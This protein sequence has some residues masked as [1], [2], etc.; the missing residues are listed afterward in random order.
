MQRHAPDGQVPSRATKSGR[1]ILQAMV[2]QTRRQPLSERFAALH[3][4]LRGILGLR[5]KE[6][7]EVRVCGLA[8]HSVAKARVI[9]AESRAKRGRVEDI[10]VAYNREDAICK[11]RLAQALA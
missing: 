9:R 10:E 5:G 8:E 2:A 4:I 7:C 11:E 3:V 1:H 6:L